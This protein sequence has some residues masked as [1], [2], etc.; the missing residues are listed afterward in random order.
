M[1]HSSFRLQKVTVCQEKEK[2][3]P[4]DLRLISDLRKTLADRDS[5]LRLLTE[6]KRFYQLELLKQTPKHDYLHN[7]HPAVGVYDPLQSLHSQRD[8][9]GEEFVPQGQT[10]VPTE[11]FLSSSLPPPGSEVR[12]GRTSLRHRGHSADVPGGAQS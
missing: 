9:R 6:E 5:E 3:L 7:S 1:F 10:H 11:R 2:S 12:K 4:E 8:G